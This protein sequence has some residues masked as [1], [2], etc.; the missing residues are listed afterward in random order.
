MRAK[1]TQKITKDVTDLTE[2]Q[3]SQFRWLRQRGADDAE[4][5][6]FFAVWPKGFLFEGPQ[7]EE[8][9]AARL[10]EPVE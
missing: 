6:Q 8:M 5:K 3:R 4:Q 10:A 1:A 9:I 2:E 7:A